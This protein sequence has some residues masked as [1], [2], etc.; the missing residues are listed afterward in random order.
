M[1]ALAASALWLAVVA[2]SRDAP[3]VAGDGGDGGPALRSTGLAQT[4]ARG[5]RSATRP[6]ACNGAAE[7]CDRT[8]DA[9]V[10][11]MTHNAMSNADERWN[12]PNQTHPPARQLADGVR[13]MM[14]DL[15]YYDA[16]QKVGSLEPIAD[17]ASVD[18]VY[19]CHG[20][21][22]LG[23]R[24]LLDAL[25]DV[26]RFLDE[27]PGE[28]VSIIF[29]TKVTD[30]D[31]DAVL[32]ASGLADYALAHEAD[33]PWPTLRAMIDAGKRAV[34]FVESGGGAPPYLHPAF[35]SNIR[36][37]PYSFERASDF[38][39]KVNRGKA[40]DPLF[41]VNHWL[42]RPLADVALAREVNVEAVLGKRVG[43]CTREAGRKATFVGVD[44]YEVGDLFAV[45]RKAN[46]LP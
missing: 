45:V 36:D 17:L 8:Y 35:R 22:S 23:N 7:L 29:E 38:S 30:A 32:R 20:L 44:F 18:R 6:A 40:G 27:N 43:D 25:C 3:T 19:L 10:V 21:C 1:R 16:D 24:R 34:V 4:C 11:P 9:V 39:C 28:I 13:G 46:G 37:T 26:T 12:V 15:H 33:K 31:T 14:L 5:A 41:L 42:G 2:C